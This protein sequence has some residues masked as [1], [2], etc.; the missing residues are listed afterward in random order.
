MSCGDECGGVRSHDLDLS[1]LL[2]GP[3]CSADG[4]GSTDG[5]SFI[6]GNSSSDIS[7]PLVGLTVP[8]GLCVRTCSLTR[9]RPSP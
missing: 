1:S 6:S 8:V 3:L 4:C 2:E 5:E 7:F 9:S